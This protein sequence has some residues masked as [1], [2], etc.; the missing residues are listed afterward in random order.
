MDN[1]EGKHPDYLE[2]DPVWDKLSTLLDGKVG[3]DFS[4]EDLEKLYRD[5]KSDMMKRFLPDIWT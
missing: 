4:K 2:N 3:D 5:G 1:L